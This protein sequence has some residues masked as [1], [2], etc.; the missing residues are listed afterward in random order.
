ME[1]LNDSM[2]AQLQPV[3]IELQ[4]MLSSTT[5]NLNAFCFLGMLDMSFTISVVWP[6]ITFVI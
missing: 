3:F 4:K 1:L 6:P 2:D 5:F